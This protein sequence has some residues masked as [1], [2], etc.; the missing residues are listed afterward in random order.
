MGAA[1]VDVQALEKL[2]DLY[3][4]IA[5][6]P[7][8]LSGRISQRSGSKNVEV[9]CVW[10]NR[11]I[12]MK[13]SIMTQRLSVVAPRPD[14]T[15]LYNLVSTTSLPLS[16]FESQSTAYSK[17]NDK[18]ANLITI[19]DGKD[20]KQY[21]KIFDLLEHQELLCADVTTPKKH[22]L[23]YSPGDF[24]KLSW[25]NGGGHLL[26]TAEKFVKT[27]QYFDADLDWSNDEKILESNVGDKFEYVESWGEQ[28][29]DVCRPVLCIMDVLSGS[30]TVLDGVS[31][32][33]SP[34]QGIWAPNDE[35]IV[36]Y[37]LKNYPFKL[38]KIFCNNRKGTLYYY[39]FSTAAV[40]PLSD[41]DVGIES[42]SF[43]PDN[44]KLIYFQRDADAPHNAAFALHV[45]D[46]S[47]KKRKVVVPIVRSPESPDSFP[48]FFVMQ[49]GNQCWCED[50]NRII[51]STAWGA[52]L[53]IVVVN[54]NAG[55]LTK[56]TNIGQIHGSWSLLDVYNDLILVSCSSPTRPP[57]T[58]LGRLPKVGNEE[59]IIWTSLD[60]STA[61]EERSK[62]LNFTWKIVQFQRPGGK[63]YEG[64]LYMPKD[65]DFIPLVAIP[66]GGPHGH[67]I[68]AWPRRDFTLLLNSGY[69]ILQVNYHGSAG[70]GDDFIRSLPGKC[71]DLEVNDVKHAIETVLEG[72]ERLDKDSV[73][74]YGG[75]HGGFIVSHL[76]GQNP[77]AYKACVALNPVLNIADMFEI[78]DIPDWA[79]ACAENKVPDWTEPLTADQFEKM[80]KTSPA[81]YVKN[82]VTP[83]LLL[84][85]E[86]DL[87]VK[88]HYGPFIRNLASRNVPYRVLT[89]PESNH[90]LLEVDVEADFA[91][92]VVRWF[93]AHLH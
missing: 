39:D 90:Q 69:A 38:G 77:G 44:S 5:Q 74:L 81:A 2:K 68:A 70:Y 1:T 55:S 15:Q 58:L 29:T 13:K 34:A 32:T 26:Y 12:V 20:K 25:S 19:Q 75:S 66:H 54:V 49:I 76:I 65:G 45:V 92:E 87:R 17:K 21:M 11:A 64:I 88:S 14:D 59:M 72:N 40:T 85:G 33:I 53:E 24:G 37:G 79:V 4:D 83:Y 16:T 31:D 86:K 80:R 71:G 18:I 41:E 82:V 51:L 57:T 7:V 52:K 93:D 28:L 50:N 61:V 56:I 10:S 62:L 43:S 47:T 35:G 42:F 3:A 78:S 46:W 48:G 9:A 27:A 60:N 63:P 84:I 6:V 73:G 36:F 89:Y 22:G 91:I 23:V 67:S 30:V 8:P